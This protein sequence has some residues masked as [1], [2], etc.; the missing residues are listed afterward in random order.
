MLYT[1]L[2]SSVLG[3]TMPSVLSADPKPRV[4]FFSNTD[5]PADE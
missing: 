4:Q 3:K 5:L 2:A 1:S